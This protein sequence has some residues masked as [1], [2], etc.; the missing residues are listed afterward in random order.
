MAYINQERKAKIAPQI[1]AVLKKYN[2]KGSIAISNHST[3]VVNIKSGAIDFIGNANKIAQQNIDAGRRDR[4]A[5]D[6]IQV[7]EFW[8]HEHFSGKAKKFLDELFAAIKS[9]GWFDNSDIQ[10][11]Y[12]HVDFYMSVN[13]GSWNRPYTVVA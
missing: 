5:Q 10:T 12:F 4:I 13:V 1:K 3:L 9:D 7:N 2:V 6:Y 8:Y 11:D